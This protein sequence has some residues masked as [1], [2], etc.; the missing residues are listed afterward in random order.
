M[1]TPSGHNRVTPP[2]PLEWQ[3]QLARVVSG[4]LVFETLSGLGIYLLPFSVSTQMTV[5]FHTA[6]GLVFV[7]PYLW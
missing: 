5:L 2:K 7:A 1:S 4:L 3:R 6:A